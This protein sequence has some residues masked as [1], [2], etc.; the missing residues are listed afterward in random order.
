[1]AAL[2][3]GRRRL[4]RPGGLRFAPRPYVGP[5]PCQPC[6]RRAGSRA[7][8]CP[9]AARPQELGGERERLAG[10]AGRADGVERP[11]TVGGGQVRRVRGSIFSQGPDGPVRTAQRVRSRGLVRRTASTCLGARPGCSGRA[12]RTVAAARTTGR[13]GRRPRSPGAPRRCLPLLPG[14]SRDGRLQAY[15]PRRAAPRRVFRSRG[16]RV[17]AVAVRASGRPARRV[18]RQ[19]PP[20]GR[21]SSRQP[22]GPGRAL[23][24]F[25]LSDNSP[26]V[27]LRW[28]P[29]GSADS[30]AASSGP[31]PAANHAGARAGPTS[32]AQQA[33]KR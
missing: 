3:R 1:M 25:A 24:G 19:Q 33:R 4:E 9:P 29:S 5:S 26:G 28:S 16:T 31:Y 8:V 20:D 18:A 23:R 7:P 10:P 30:H 27:G 12:G 32:H 6:A 2:G 13:P 22:G 17:L 11:G 15:A 21:R 14:P